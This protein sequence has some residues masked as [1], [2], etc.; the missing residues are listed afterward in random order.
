MKNAAVIPAVGGLDA[1]ALA[2]QVTALADVAGFAADAGLKGLIL[3]GDTD[4]LSGA[5]EALGAA[6][7]P[8][9][10]ELPVP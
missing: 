2:D 10:D 4:A 5:L 8:P 1:D 7:E 9:A 6:T 3:R